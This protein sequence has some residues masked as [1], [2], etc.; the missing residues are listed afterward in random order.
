MKNATHSVMSDKTHII[1]QGEQ[2]SI[3][4]IPVGITQE[5]TPTETDNTPDKALASSWGIWGIMRGNKEAATLQPC[6]FAASDIHSMNAIIK[7]AQQAVLPRKSDGAAVPPQPVMDFGK[8]GRVC[9]LC[10]RDDYSFRLYVT[11]ADNDFMTW[12]VYCLSMHKSLL[13]MARSTSQS[14]V[15]CLGGLATG[16]AHDRH[17]KDGS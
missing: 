8:S 14:H 15:R 6:A 11:T 3:G 10:G 16:G 5:V 12:D 13:N 9:M 2:F 1:R 17:K 7:G 4:N